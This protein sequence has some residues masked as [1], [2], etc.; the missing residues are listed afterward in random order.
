MSSTTQSASRNG[1]K[2]RP[3]RLKKFITTIVILAAV[4][5][6]GWWGWMKTHPAEDPSSKMITT[7]VAKGDL[8][9]SITATGSVTAQTG[10]LVKIG[11]QITGRI[12]RLYADV[13]SKVT[14]GQVIAEL[15]LPDIRAQVAQAE[16][17]SNGAQIKAIQQQTGVGMER[18]QTNSAILQARAALASSQARLVSA[19]ATEKLQGVQ[20]PTDIRK[21]ESAVA[22]TQAALSTAKSNFNQVNVSAKLQVANA[23]EQLN[24]AQANAR[25]SAANLTRQTQLNAKGFVS[26]SVLDEAKASDSVNRSLVQSA[27]QNIGLVKEKIQADTQTAQDQVTQAEQNIVSAKAGLDAARAGTNQDQV[28]KAEVIDARAQV[29][30]AQATLNLALGNVAQDQLKLQ[31]VSQAKDSAQAAR[32]Q[33]DFARAQLDKTFIRSPISGTVLQLAAQQ[34]ETL[35]A[36]LSAP[37]L[38]VVADLNR[39]QVDIY[40]DE[41]DIGKVKLGQEAEVTVDAFPKKKLKGKV[42]KVASGSTIQQGVVTYDVTVAIEKADKRL[43]PDM[44]ATAVVQTGA[45]TN[46]LLIPAEAVKV[47]TKGSTVNVAIKKDGATETEQRKVK[48]G[49]SD[50]VMTEI[51]EGLKEGEVIVLAGNQKK[52]QGGGGPA[53]PFGPT[54]GGRGGGR[55]GGGR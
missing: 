52:Q 20:T 12:K 47:G 53:S 37:T 30:Q 24:Q 41:T 29:R 46:V 48:T 6:L 36:G 19:L 23:Q 1:S 10:A 35:A 54:G 32:A 8:S 51:R 18:I 21:A 50:G 22:A 15:D 49:G 4:G 33:V 7:T 25:N 5:G 3:K 13:G 16:A 55:G 2:P 34:G 44:T 9:E 31:D 43:K 28:R 45:L 27:Q 38:I 26:N 11:S 39:L 14:A 42:T 40:V 17:S